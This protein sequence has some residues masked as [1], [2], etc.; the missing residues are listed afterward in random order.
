MRLKPIIL[1]LF[2]AFLLPIYSCS[3]GMELLDKK[4]KKWWT[5][6]TQENRRGNSNKALELYDKILEKDPTF[7]DAY[8][9]KGGIYYNR[10][11]WEN[12]E[13]MFKRGLEINPEYNKEVYYSLALVA[14]EK[15]KYRDAESYMEGYINRCTPDDRKLEKAKQ[16]INQYKFRAEAM[17]NPVPFLPEALPF[18]IN[19]EESEYTP[20]FTVDGSK[21]LFVR[22]I[23]GQ[24]DIVISEII[25][26]FYK[27]PS[28]IEEIATLDNEG[29]FTI[30]AD[31]NKIIFT[32][33]NRRDGY[34]SCDLYYSIKDEKGKWRKPSNMGKRIN[35]PAWDSQPSLSADGKKL[36]FSS[37]RH[38][39]IGGSDLWMTEWLPEGKWSIPQN[40]GGMINTL[41]Y[42]ETPFLHPDGRTMYFRS[43]GRLGMGGFDLYK[44]TYDEQSGEWTIPKNLGYPINTEDDEG[45]LIV[46]LDGSTA[47]FASHNKKKDA[48]IYQF[49]LY[50]E[51]K[52]EPATF[53]KTIVTD[54][55]TGNPL[56]A[57]ITITNNTT[58][59]HNDLS[60]DHTGTGL[61]A[62]PAGYNYG[63]YIEKEGY[64]FYSDN[65]ALDS[66]ATSIDP[67]ILNIAL[68]PIPEE[69]VIVEEKPIILKNIFF[70]TG[71]AVLK[72]IS[73]T[74]IG[75]LKNLL[76]YDQTL[77]VTIIGH[78]DNVGTE[79]DN[80]QLSLD[81]ANAV[82]V[83]LVE[84]G[85][86]SDRIEVK[87]M[88]ESMPIDNN[89]TLAGRSNNRRTEFTVRKKG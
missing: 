57:H 55:K 46:S 24:E 42:D 4:S 74:E 1:I 23:G 79:E 30:S 33:C 32:G 72:D 84:M 25:D 34:G 67:F 82:K 56:Y 28:I 76:T 35:T 83:A 13:A 43:N 38:G 71:S 27:V 7:I 68:I 59:K 78:T 60:T 88:G 6:A 50:E 66:I 70:E 18:P 51:I 10:K 31:G 16:L 77:D 14:Q 89:D 5:E 41:G 48:D 81:R 61:S 26:S 11:D 53:V 49:E 75:K 64:L 58:G 22:R 15:K 36:I 37:R 54:A 29:V 62:L 80:L 73:Y 65:F 47:F 45:G 69:N 44:S 19:T 8:L 85:I 52:P 86:S 9:M 40:L 17:E 2:L 63:L 12:A 3:Q 21:M 39:S 87:G 20:G